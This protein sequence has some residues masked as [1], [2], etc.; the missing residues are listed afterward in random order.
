MC[1][2]IRARQVPESGIGSVREE[3][4][5]VAA[6]QSSGPGLKDH[7]VDLVLAGAVDRSVEPETDDE[8]L[9]VHDEPETSIFLSLS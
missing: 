9:P 4:E 2:D 1:R 5:V 8:D 7:D 6:Q 3:G